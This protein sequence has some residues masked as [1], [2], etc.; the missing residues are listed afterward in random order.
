MGR[1]LISSKNTPF[2][3]AG[4]CLGAAILLP[5]SVIGALIA[6]LFARPIDRSADEVAAYIRAMLDGSINDE[7]SD[8]DYDEFSCVPIA[9]P[10]LHSIARR[11]CEA[12]E[13]GPDVTAILES[14]LNETEVLAKND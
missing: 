2:Q 12:F 1:V 14:L 3:N 11:A 5:I 13:Q 6:S 8:F 10:E 7:D 9:N 4:G